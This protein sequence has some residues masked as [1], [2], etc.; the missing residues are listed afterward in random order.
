MRDHLLSPTL[1]RLLTRTPTHRLCLSQAPCSPRRRDFPALIVTRVVPFVAA[2]LLCVESVTPARA[3]GAFSATGSMG[4]ARRN[5]TA[6]LLPPG[7]T[8]Y[9]LLPVG[10]ERV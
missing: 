2:A 3:V 7:A 8:A 4:A 9:V 10:T 5:H 1:H 6:T